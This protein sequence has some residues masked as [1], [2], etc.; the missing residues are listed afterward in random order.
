M[1]KININLFSFLSF[2][3]IYIHLITKIILWVKNLLFIGKKYL[4]NIFKQKKF[5]LWK[6]LPPSPS[7]QFCHVLTQSIKYLP[8]LVTF[9]LF[10]GSLDESLEID[11]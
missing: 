5:T 7:M 8:K 11:F 4:F 9:G 2:T 1:D 3:T 6:Q 10:L